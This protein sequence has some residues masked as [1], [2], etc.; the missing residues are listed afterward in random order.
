MVDFARG[1]D[2]PIVSYQSFEIQKHCTPLNNK[3]E[4][5]FHIGTLRMT[6]VTTNKVFY[7]Q[8]TT[9]EAFQC[10]VDQ[11]KFSMMEDILLLSWPEGKMRNG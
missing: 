7:Q 10:L 1:L 11:E 5:K 6:G 4:R 3:D 2:V 9:W 8:L